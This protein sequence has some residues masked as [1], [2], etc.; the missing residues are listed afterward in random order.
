MMI[1]KL[2]IVVSVIGLFSLG[3][4]FIYGASKGH[5]NSD[6]E[7]IINADQNK[8]WSNFQN[9]GKFKKW[10]SGF[11]KIEMLEGIPGTAG[12]TYALHFLNDDG[13]SN[14]LYQKLT[15]IDA[16]NSISFDLNNEMFSS[17]LLITLQE[18]KEGTKMLVKMQT[19]G[20]NT[21]YNAFIHLGKEN[22]D[23][24]QRQNYEAFKQML[25]QE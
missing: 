12:S 21:F 3:A 20:N 25:E 11:E 1:K 24:N 17:K 14:I 9:P 23:Q 6:F 8:V 19:E 10:M 2:A 15:S 18:A 22:I 16:P 13:T 4:V 7:T 5:L